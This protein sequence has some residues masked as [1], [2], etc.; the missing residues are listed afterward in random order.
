MAG[1]QKPNQFTRPDGEVRQ[2]QMVSTFGPGAL[3]DLVEDAVVIS[4]LDHWHFGK[5]KQFIH[6]PRLRDDLVQ[7]FQKL[8]RKLDTQNPFRSAP[9][10]DSRAA[11]KGHGVDALEFPRWVVCQNSD[12][13]A[14]VRSNNLDRKRGYYQHV[15]DDGKAN[16]CVP[17][18]FAAACRNGHLD[19][20][21]WVHWL[22]DKPKGD[23][24]QSPRLKLEDGATGDFAEVVVSC[25]ACGARRK[26]LEASNE[27]VNPSCFGARPWLGSEG[28]EP[29]GETIRMLTRSASNAYFSQVESALSIPDASVGLRE[30]VKDQWKILQVVQNA[31]MLQGFL[32]IPQLEKLKTFPVQDVL[33]AIEDER[34]HKDPGREPIRNAEYRQLL[35]SKDEVPGHIPA[36][37]EDFHACRVPGHG[38]TGIKSVILVKKLRQVRVQVG[39]TRL[40]DQGANLQGEFDLEVRSAA[41]SLTQDW[42]PATEIRGEGVFIEL[43][44]EM[45]HAWELSPA[46]MERTADLLKGFDQWKKERKSTLDFPGARFYLLHSLGHLL[47]T[48]LALECGY[49]AS[50]LTERIYC[51]PHGTLMPMAGLLLLTGSSSTEGTLGGLVEEGRR[52]KDHLRRALD[53]ARLCS[54][55]PV[56]SQHTPAG[57]LA[58]RHLEG[59]AC[60][61][62]LF[63]AECSCERFNRFLDRA[64]VVP[65]LGPAGCAYFKATS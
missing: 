49:P 4:G 59:A 26:L 61:G 40:E 51:A 56:C 50:A 8:G 47:M 11:W 16:P 15:C 62:C 6:E 20:W 21:P 39:F 41:L 52:L 64:L 9:V 17:V 48:A 57:D 44:E 19:E 2:S 3:V 25:K 13:R 29:C 22:H 23:K 53:M 35:M 24:C 36:S 46:V 1:Q 14:L 31:A 43:D 38:V 18:R 54:N 58:E 33:D 45:V 27:K 65:T 32:I 42:L 10:G 12:C 37:E 7:R 30:V 63:V 5:A 28:K 60:H 55:D 34:S